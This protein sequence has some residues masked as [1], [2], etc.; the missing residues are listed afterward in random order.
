MTFHVISTVDAS[1]V[2]HSVNLDVTSYTYNLPG[3][4]HDPHGQYAGGVY[5]VQLNFRAIAY[6]TQYFKITYIVVG[7]PAQANNAYPTIFTTGDGVNE[8]AAIDFGPELTTTPY[9]YTYVTTLHLTRPH[10]DNTH[11][12]LNPSVRWSLADRHGGDWEFTIIVEEISGGGA[13]IS[14]PNQISMIIEQN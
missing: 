11:A 10:G 7:T 2:T 4:G 6:D 12:N 3:Y 13:I 14:H 1:A 5:D 9:S 8:P